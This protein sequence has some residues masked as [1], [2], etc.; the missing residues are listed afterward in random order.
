[1]NT[2][3]TKAVKELDD[4]L[5]S[6]VVFHK[7]SEIDDLQYYLD[8]WNQVLT[9]NRMYFVIGECK[10]RDIDRARQHEINQEKI[11]RQYDNDK[12]RD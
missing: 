1:M 8:K 7:A 10:S 4:A 2:S 5:C 11:Q 3:I 6:G 12:F 9:A